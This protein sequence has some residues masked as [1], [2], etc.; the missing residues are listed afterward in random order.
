MWPDEQATWTCSPRH[1]YL[2]SCEQR[3]LL[4][5]PRL[6]QLPSAVLPHP[7]RPHLASAQQFVA[8]F[9][10]VAQHIFLGDEGLEACV[11]LV[12]TVLSAGGERGQQ[13]HLISVGITRQ[14]VRCLGKQLQTWRSA[15]ESK[16]CVAD[17]DLSGNDISIASAESCPIRSLQP[18]LRTTHLRRLL[19]RGCRCAMLSILRAFCGVILEQAA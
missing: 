17:V 11:P 12:Q 2:Q 3:R 13:L 9:G 14:G 10:F 5:H 7:S 6:L 19:L 1:M 8:A 16:M 15:A 18:V 4:P